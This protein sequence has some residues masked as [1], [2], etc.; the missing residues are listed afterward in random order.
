LNIR[1]FYEYIITKIK[2]DSKINNIN[3][4]E[5]SIS[6]IYTEQI[7]NIIIILIKIAYPSIS[8]SNIIRELRE[9]RNLVFINNPL[10][11]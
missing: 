11:F 6:I 10:N 8:A 3:I 5:N 2:V 7:K 1:Y 9:L 4:N